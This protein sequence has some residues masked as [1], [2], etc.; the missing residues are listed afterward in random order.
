MMKSIFLV[1]AISG[2]G[3]LDSYARL[4]S[5][6]LLELGH[7]VVLVAATDG[8]TADYLARNEVDPT[9]Y[10]FV[11]F[12][13]ASSW[14]PP[15]AASCPPGV[16]GPRGRLS[17]RARAEFVWQEEGAVGILRRLVAVPVRIGAR[18]TPEPARLRWRMLK[19]AFL[20]RL[21][22]FRAM[23]ALRRVLFPDAGRLLFTTMTQRVQNAVAIQGGEPPD[24]V[25]FLYLDMMA[26]RLVDIAALDAPDSGPW[27]GIRFHPRLRES[28]E[29][30]IER[31]F[32]SQNARGSLF[33]VPQADEI[34]AK[35]MPRLKFLLAPDV[36]DLELATQLPSVA[37]EIRSR[38]ADRTIVL[39]IGTIAPHKGV[40]MLLDVIAK[41]DPQRFFFA[42]VGEV[43]WRSFGNDERKLR[44]FYEQT[45]E[46]VVTYDGYMAEERDYNSLVAAC[47]VVYAVYT[48]F[49]SSSNSLAKAAGLR[50]PILAARNSLMGER[51]V[52]HRIG[53]AAANDDV[54]EIIAALECLAATKD[55][56]L[57]FN[58]YADRHS[59]GELKSVLAEGLSLWL[60]EPDTSR[61]PTS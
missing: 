13:E 15:A 47:D 37:R 26:E 46:N 16:D 18:L 17:T 34:Y 5:R 33:L 50:R 3:H 43:Y 58:E 19:R 21:S 35:A 6:T 28:P 44:N 38:A 61:S 40:M 41:A 39:Q 8:G 20:T 30:R 55:N 32:E 53:L 22:P 31:Y 9:R 24:L 12:S 29:A 36:A 1:N 54:Q 45:P 11:S 2:H 56:G 27:A 14:R 4:Y 52:A 42:L 49:N 57:N 51:V 25:F 23:Q 60:A 48:D 10:S 59:L 7:R